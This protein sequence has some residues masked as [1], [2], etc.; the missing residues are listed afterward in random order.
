[1][2]TDRQIRAA[3]AA[4]RDYKLADGQGLH[5]LVTKGGAKLWRYRYAHGGKEKMLSF[6]RYPEVTLA[7][8][9]A[10]RQ[11]ARDLLRAGRDP[12]LAR[13]LHRAS[14]LAQAE[15][16]LEAVARRWHKQMTPGWTPTHAGDVLQSLEAHAFPMLGALPIR[17]IT[18]PMILAALREIEA[19]PAIETAHRVG[20][21][22]SAIFIH[23]VAEGL[24]ETDP[25]ATA[26]KALRPV[27]RGRQPALTDLAELRQ[28]LQAAESIPAHPVTRLGL[29][30]LALTALRPGELRAATWG[31]FEDLDGLEPLWRVPAR[32]M[33][34]RAEH[35][36]PLSTQAVEVLAAVRV[37]TGRG[38]LP[39]P[40]TRHAHKP[41]S[42]NAL[43]Y[44]LNRAGY[45]HRHVPHG[46]RAGFSSVMNERFRED[47]AVID[48]MLAHAPKDRVESAYN[49][50]VHL[51][52]R[53][54]L[55]QAWADL[56]LEG[57]APAASLLTGARR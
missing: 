45:H 28:V 16:T 57:A 31:E 18:T 8:A 30:L 10:E 11:A 43:G 48:L 20:Q 5:L 46:W 54:E 52:R 12:S 15:N 25:A 23:A 36:V 22:L 24:A 32:R 2:L 55:A 42:E 41:M 21:R 35:L 19:R 4:E 49:R 50:A 40:S 34:M 3:A 53:R 9:R 38:P 33:K 44:L 26:R 27:V 51:A 47:R 39:F 7:A 1:V 29:R 13:K 14:S 17:E 6:G 56:L 37:L